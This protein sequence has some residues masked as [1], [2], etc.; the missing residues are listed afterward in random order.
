MSLKPK[1]PKAE[2][3]TKPSKKK[4]VLKESFTKVKAAFKN[5]FNFK[6]K[7]KVKT[8]KQKNGK[9]V[10]I[11][12]AVLIFAIIMTSIGLLG[13]IGGS[14][15]VVKNEKPT[16]SDQGSLDINGVVRQYKVNAGA[17]VNAGDFVEF[18]PKWGEVP[19]TELNPTIYKAVSLSYD[20]IAVIYAVPNAIRCA[21]LKINDN[22]YERIFDQDLYVYDG[23]S[24]TELDADV[25]N[26]TDIVVGCCITKRGDTTTRSGFCFIAR[27]SNNYTEV[28]FGTEQY[29]GGDTGCEAVV[30]RRMTNDKIVYA[31]E[32][33]SGSAD[34]VVSEG[35]LFYNVD[36]LSFDGK[37]DGQNSVVKNIQNNMKDIDICVLD[38]FHYV[39]ARGSR[40]DFMFTDDSIISVQSYKDSIPGGSLFFV[41]ESE[42]SWFAINK[43]LHR[44]NYNNGKLSFRES[45]DILSNDSPIGAIVSGN[46][47]FM[48]YSD[49]ICSYTLNGAD[50][51]VSTFYSVERANFLPITSNGQ[52]SFIGVLRAGETLVYGFNVADNGTIRPIKAEET[53]LVIQKATTNGLPIGIAKTSGKEGD[54]I[55]VYCVK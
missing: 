43:Y 1:K 54:I 34:C 48:L 28:T 20:K 50:K 19:V 42:T 30:V 36:T 27:F 11:I 26:E 12:S 53:G 46:R 10:Q 33:K 15:T 44:I 52:N 25:I 8:P 18:V 17:T 47:I 45:D 37:I 14:N 38:D 40:I 49:K 31:F 6:A 39:I 4:N 7:R 55:E 9:K 29:L 3:K 51:V 21:V 2:K 35:L 23:A 5:A 24:F 41:R 32:K 16:I 22:S 13:N